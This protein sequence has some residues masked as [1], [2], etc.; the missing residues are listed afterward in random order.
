MCLSSSLSLCS[1]CLSL[2]LSQ[3]HSMI[4]RKKYI[5]AGLALVHPTY[6][7]RSMESTLPHTSAHLHCLKSDSVFG[8][9]TPAT[10]TTPL[11]TFQ[12]HTSEYPIRCTNE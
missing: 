6:D 10:G 9:F 4:L 12:F 8:D 3:K 2:S 1:L 5:N 7:L 11:L